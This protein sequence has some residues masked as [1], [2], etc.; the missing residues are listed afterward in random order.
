MLM[1]SKMLYCGASLQSGTSPVVSFSKIFSISDNYF[2]EHLRVFFIFFF[3][4]PT[5]TVVGIISDVLEISHGNVCGE[6]LIKV[7]VCQH[8]VC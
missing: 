5:E 2:Q 3:F 6:I 4:S 7:A 8:E 1:P